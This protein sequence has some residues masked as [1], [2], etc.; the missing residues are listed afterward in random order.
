MK[1]YGARDQPRGR[2][3]STGDVVLVQSDTDLVPRP[4]PPVELGA[5]EADEWR[6]ICNV[7]PADY[8]PAAT[9]KIVVQY[10]RHVVVARHLAELIAKCGRAKRAFPLAQYLQLIREQRRETAAIYVCLRSM[11]LTHLATYSKDRAPIAAD[12]PKPWE[13]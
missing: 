3:P 9:H 11:R 12:T 6:A 13:T 7:V 4:E 10:C 8:F 2:K 1:R 5:E